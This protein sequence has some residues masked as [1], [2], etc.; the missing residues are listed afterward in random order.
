MRESL[1]GLIVIGDHLTGAFGTF[2]A[3]EAM[4]YSTAQSFVVGSPGQPSPVLFMPNPIISSMGGVVIPSPN[5][6]GLGQPFFQPIPS[7]S[8]MHVGQIQTTTLLRGSRPAQPPEPILPRKLPPL[9]SYE[10]SGST[11][12][13]SYIVSPTNL[14]IIHHHRFTIPEPPPPVKASKPAQVE[15]VKT[16]SVSST[17]RDSNEESVVHE[18]ALSIPDDSEHDTESH[19]SNADQVSKETV[20]H[21]EVD[22]DGNDDIYGGIPL[23]SKALHSQSSSDRV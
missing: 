18:T 5:S 17:V 11:K 16:S 7:A 8:G 9:E 23:V 13:A 15:P 1:L 20:T 14:E 10:S 4:P 3:S 19:D 2:Q 12:A 6:F 21:S 22:S